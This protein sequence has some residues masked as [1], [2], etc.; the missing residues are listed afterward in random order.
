MRVWKN[1]SERESRARRVGTLICVHV[2]NAVANC[3]K[4]LLNWFEVQR[5]A[6]LCFE[7][8]RIGETDFLCACVRVQLSKNYYV[9]PATIVNADTTRFIVPVKGIHPRDKLRTI[10]ARMDVRTYTGYTF[11]KVYRVFALV[12]QKRIRVICQNLRSTIFE[13]RYTRTNRSQ[14]WLKLHG[15]YL[16]I[17]C[18][19][20]YY[21]LSI[22]TESAMFHNFFSASNEC[23]FAALH[24]LFYA[25]P[26]LYLIV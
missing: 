25:Y 26:F 3:I 10:F 19:Y 23:S 18:K 24:F 17:V 9:S 12:S 14:T 22:L 6:R 2:A 1:K 8:A 13:I 16:Y 20:I 11:A 15:A 7:R 4:L 5:W 21:Y